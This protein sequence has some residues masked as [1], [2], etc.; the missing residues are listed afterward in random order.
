MY[1]EWL[2]KYKPSMVEIGHEPKKPGGGH[3]KGKS[4]SG[5]QRANSL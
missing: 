3:S 1:I 2:I 5:R 4:F